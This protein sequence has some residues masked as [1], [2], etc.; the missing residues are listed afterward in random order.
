MWWKILIAVLCLVLIVS[1]VD[2]SPAMLGI[3]DIGAFAGLVGAIISAI[4]GFKLG[5]A[6]KEEEDDKYNDVNQN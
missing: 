2:F 5:R 1:P 6:S 3:D 4:K